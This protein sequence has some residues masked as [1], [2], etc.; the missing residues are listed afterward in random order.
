VTADVFGLGEMLSHPFMRHAF[1]AGTAV[2]IACGLVGYFLVLRA[3]VFAGDVLSHV[4]FTGALAA[5]AFGVDLRLGLLVSVVA[6]ALVL[7]VLGDR[8]HAD[9]VTIGAVFVWVLGLGVLFL[10]LLTSGRSTGNSGAGVTVLFGSITGLD[11]TSTVTAVLVGV[12]VVVGIVAIARPLLFASV[13]ASVAATMG[14]PVRTLGI[15]FLG[16]LGLTAAEATQAVGALLL[17]GL[18]A[19]PAAAAR[20]LTARPY[21]GLLLSAGLAVAAM[22]V[23]LVVS[24]AVPTVPASFAIVAAA[25]A[26]YVIAAAVPIGRERPRSDAADASGA[27][28]STSVH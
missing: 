23:G 2:A 22:W 19:A 8:G 10:S 5:L 17:F 13:D 24:W 20:R 28:R 6:V 12:V 16:L 21:R 26:T 9:D 7:G 18:L 14:V 27:G 15:V 11:R 25:T 3:Q 4:A 1:V